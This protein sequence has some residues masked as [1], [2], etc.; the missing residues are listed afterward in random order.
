MDSNNSNNPNNVKKIDDRTIE[1]GGKTF[2]SISV[3]DSTVGEGIIAWLLFNFGFF[4][5]T[6]YCLYLHTNKGRKYT[7][8]GYLGKTSFAVFMLLLLFEIIIIGLLLIIFLVVF[9]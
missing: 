6:F 4:P 2:T 8:Y 9:S 5:L 3:E 7:C 1:W